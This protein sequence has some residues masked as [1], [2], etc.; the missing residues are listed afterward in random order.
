MEHLSI[1]HWLILFIMVVFLL[2]PYAR[3]IRRA[4]FSPW[5]VL[6]AFVPMLNLI[7]IW[8]FAFVQWPSLERK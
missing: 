7:M 1:W 5:W 6:L 2:Y 8:V 3:I 4:G